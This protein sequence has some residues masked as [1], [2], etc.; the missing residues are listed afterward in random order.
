MNQVVVGQAHLAVAKGLAESDPVVLNAARTFFAMTIDCHVYSA[1]M[2][3]ARLHDETRGAVTVRT[4]LERARQ[5]AGATQYATRAEVRAAIISGEKVLS[6]LSAPLG[7]LTRRR[8]VWLAH[9]DP[10]TLTDPAKMATIAAT[11][12]PDLQK[13]FEGTGGIVNDFSRLFRDI[14]GILELFSQTDYETVVEYV[15]D[16]KCGQVRRYEAEFGEPA[17][18]PRP[19]GCE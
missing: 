7:A 18:F 15:S 4:L 9:N 5:E 11:T 12:F 8:N 1:Q 10:R 16:V 6:K 2:H 19:R 13:I 14:T 3:A 17:P